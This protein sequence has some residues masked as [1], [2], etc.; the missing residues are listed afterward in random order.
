M[1]RDCL[2]TNGYR[3][4]FWGDENVLKLDIDDGRITLC[5]H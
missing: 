1:K 4:P 5:I 3:F 2:F